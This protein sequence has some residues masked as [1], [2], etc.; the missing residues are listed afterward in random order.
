M[1]Q[2]PLL[3]SFSLACFFAVFGTAITQEFKLFAF[4]PFLAI[5]YNRTELQKAL[6]I[7][8][9][10]GAFIDLLSSEFVLGLHAVCYSLTT[11]MLFKQK[12]HFFED[13]PLALSLFTA[14]I[15]MVATGM[16]LLLIS[17]F[18]RALPLSVKLLMT[19]FLLMPLLDGVYAFFWFS[20]P[21]MLYLHI[22]KVGWRAFYSKVLFS[23]RLQRG[24]EEKM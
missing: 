14:L 11:L 12:K 16:Q 17:I 6:W 5:V 13:K 18:D 21:M 10:C 22:K 23:F 7:A 19:D 9:L 2:I 4:A 1:R 24:D 8:A 20:C 3:F 15:S